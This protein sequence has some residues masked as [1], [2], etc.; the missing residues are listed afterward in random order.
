VS[1]FLNHRISNGAVLSVTMIFF[2]TLAF[3]VLEKAMAVIFPHRGVDKKRHFLVSVVIPYFF[4]LFLGIAMLGVTAVSLILQALAEETIHVFGHS[5]QLRGISGV[6]LNI[7][8]FSAE[9]LILTVVYL[10]L[11]VGRIQPRHA[12]IGGLMAASLWEIVRRILFWYFST[13]SSAGIV[14]GSLTTAVVALFSMEI[15]AIVL[16]LGAQ[17]ISEYEQIG[18]NTS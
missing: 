4:V 13:L 8:G 18:E 5:W 9:I 12:V 14:Y 15:A 10:V 6:L 16:L 11:P 17:V 3:S 1:R 7:L 2:S